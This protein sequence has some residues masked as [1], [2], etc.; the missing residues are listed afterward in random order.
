LNE[1]RN[2]ELRILITVRDYAYNDISNQ[3][4][5]YNPATVTLNKLTD[6]QIKIILQS[7]DFQINNP[8]FIERILSIADGNPRLAVMA[9][10]IA[11]QK[12]NLMALEDVSDLY[13]RYLK[14]L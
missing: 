9:A 14:T 4:E 5:V 10:I 12:Q 1:K 8:Q 2:G 11:L 6:D 7:E 13:D 3:C